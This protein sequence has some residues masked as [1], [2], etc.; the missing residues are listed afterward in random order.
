MSK[1]QRK[2]FAFELK[3]STDDGTFV[4]IASVYGNKDLQ[5]DVVDKGAFTK[6]LSERGAEVPILWQHDPTMPIGLGTLTDTPGGLKITG[7]LSL[8]TTKGRDAYELL[9]DGVVTGLSIGYDVIKK[10]F[11]DGARHL[12]ELKLYEVS[13]VTFPANEDALVG[14]VKSSD[15]AEL[16]PAHLAVVGALLRKDASLQ[17][18]ICA[19][20]DAVNEQFPFGNAY[21]VDVFDDHAIVSAGDRL[22]SIALTWTDA[23]GDGEMDDP[24]LGDITEVERVYVAVGAGP[25]A[26]ADAV[27][28]MK[29]GRVISSANH[30]RLKSAQDHMAKASAHVAAV[31]DAAKPKKPAVGKSAGTPDLGAAPAQDDPEILQSLRALNE[32]M[33][34]TSAV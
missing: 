9:K 34:P 32:T 6:T 4:G 11:K 5:G 15:L 26:L 13:T 12:Q 25:K 27:E 21:V 20:Y 10:A 8:G 2:A 30:E 3:S 31:V 22:F 16:K 23:E 19:V 7:K 33:R 14:A 24:V 17:D 29:A 28:E 1:Y 18:K